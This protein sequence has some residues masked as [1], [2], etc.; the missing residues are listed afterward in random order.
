MHGGGTSF[1]H[2]W[3]LRITKITKYDEYFDR[4]VQNIFDYNP[5]KHIPETLLDADLL[6]QPTWQT[7]QNKIIE[8]FRYMFSSGFL[9]SCVEL[10]NSFSSQKFTS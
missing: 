2:I 3:V 8:H 4:N 5:N 1:P 6:L 9:S 10:K 7:F